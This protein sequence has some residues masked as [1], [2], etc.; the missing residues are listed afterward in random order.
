MHV[1]MALSKDPHSVKLIKTNEVVERRNRR[2]EL[3]ISFNVFEHWRV[4]PATKRSA[5][6]RPP[7]RETPQ[8]REIREA[9][10]SRTGACIDASESRRILTATKKLEAFQEFHNDFDACR[11]SK[12]IHTSTPN[13]LIS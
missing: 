11:M 5:G 8:K 1:F 3:E 6:F 12:H 4:S 10:E 2:A 13:E 7:K 9:L